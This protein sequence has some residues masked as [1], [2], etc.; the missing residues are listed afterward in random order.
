MGALGCRSERNR[1]T[2]KDGRTRQ[3]RG[4]F[5]ADIRAAV[6]ACRAGSGADVLNAEII[7]DD[8]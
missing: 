3:V 5:T 8:L 4:Y 7:E 6:D 2:G 1:I